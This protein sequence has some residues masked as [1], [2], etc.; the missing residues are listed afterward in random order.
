LES[1]T[2]DNVDTDLDNA[3]IQWAGLTAA[4]KGPQRLT[5]TYAFSGKAS[6]K[7]RRFLSGSKIDPIT[8]MDGR[9]HPTRVSSR[10]SGEESS[11]PC[12]LAAF[13]PFKRR[14]GAIKPA[15]LPAVTPSRSG[16]SWWDNETQVLCTLS[17]ESARQTCMVLFQS[18]SP[19][20]SRR[21]PPKRPFDGV[22]AKTSEFLKNGGR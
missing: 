4:S 20:G 8:G 22:S 7:L 19:A 3:A 21:F 16:T 11:T 14:G 12:A 2:A 1:P 18:E 17:S 13:A 9:E 15:C 5:G 10:K 6:Q